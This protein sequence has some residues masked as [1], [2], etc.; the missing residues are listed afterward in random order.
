MKDVKDLTKEDR[1]EVYRKAREIYK[2]KITL[3]SNDENY[4]LPGMCWCIDIAA[5]Y[6]MI[7]TQVCSNTSHR[8]SVFRPYLRKLYWPEFDALNTKNQGGYWWPKWDTESR[9]KAFDKL[10]K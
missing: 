8:I 10:C 4:E 1:L 7:N 6:L 5:K 3:Y 9:L 2:N